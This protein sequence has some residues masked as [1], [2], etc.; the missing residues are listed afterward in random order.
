[1]KAVQWRFRNCRVFCT[2][3]N[4]LSDTVPCTRARRRCGFRLML[5][6]NRR[7]YR[8]E[9]PDGQAMQPILN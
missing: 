9:T 7:K 3:L 8:Q 4:T 2:H 6:K 5:S 1:M